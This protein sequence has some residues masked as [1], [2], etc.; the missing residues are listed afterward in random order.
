M[1][2]FES[3]G[4]FVTILVGEVNVTSTASNPSW[5]V[6]FVFVTPSKNNLLIAVDESAG[7]LISAGSYEK[8]DGLS[9]DALYSLL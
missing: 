5:V 6:N 9:I 3:P 4:S 2:S 7:T 8:L 1:S